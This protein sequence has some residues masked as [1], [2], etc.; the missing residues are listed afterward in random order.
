MNALKLIEGR[1]AGAKSA[2]Q[3][4]RRGGRGNRLPAEVRDVEG[5][6][7]ATPVHRHSLPP[8]GP[9][10]SRWSKELKAVWRSLREDVPWLRKSD[11]KIVIRYCRLHVMHEASYRA[12]CEHG[13]FVLNKAGAMVDSPHWQHWMATGHRLGQIEQRLGMTPADQTRV[14][15]NG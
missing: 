13:E 7:T 15:P 2:L 11:R 10:P 12:L 3:Q 4:A 6:R 9:A 8:I 14:V 1:G 5:T